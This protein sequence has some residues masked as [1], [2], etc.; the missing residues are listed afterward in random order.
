MQRNETGMNVL[1]H[2][3]GPDARAGPQIE[4]SCRVVWNDWRTVELLEATHEKDLVVDVE[5]VLLFL[6]TG[7]FSR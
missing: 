4:D 1:C 3:Y 6:Q 2:A 7:Q 5:P